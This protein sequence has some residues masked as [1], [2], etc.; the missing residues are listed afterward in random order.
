M[1]RDF[2]NVDWKYMVLLNVLPISSNGGQ[3]YESSL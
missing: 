2:Y 1:L 3:N